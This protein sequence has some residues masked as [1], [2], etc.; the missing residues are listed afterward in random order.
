MK[1][2]PSKLMT[3]GRFWSII[4]DSNHGRRLKECLAPLSEDELFGY[5]YWW[6]HFCNMSYRQDLCAVA[7]VVLGG[8]SDDSFDYF[9]FWLIARG[10]EVFYKALEDADSLCDV[11]A[12][13][14]DPED[15]DYPEQEE[16]DY[17]VIEV[18]EERTGDEDYFIL[19]QNAIPC[20][21]ARMRLILSGMRTTKS[22][23]ARYARAHLTNGGATMCSEHGC[24][25]PAGIG[26]NGWPPACRHTRYPKPW[27]GKRPWRAG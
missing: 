1:K 15:N 18:L 2:D 8:C 19:Q 12:K 26:H 7:Y 27:Q 13:L 20:R 16:L 9:R 23:Y 11:F 4:E 3:E 24:I 6:T 14:E 21:Y 22:L 25:L 10:R 17:A 5:M